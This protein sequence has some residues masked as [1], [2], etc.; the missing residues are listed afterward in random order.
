MGHPDETR[1][2]VIADRQAVIAP[3]WSIHCATATRAYT[4]CW[5]MG[6]ENQTFD[7]MD[8]LKVSELR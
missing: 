1:H 3:A 2:L 5:A 8:G 6:G 7:D 4:F